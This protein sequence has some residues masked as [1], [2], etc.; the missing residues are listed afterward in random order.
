MAVSEQTRSSRD[1]S[2]N[3]TFNCKRK[4]ECVSLSVTPFIRLCTRYWNAVNTFRGARYQLSSTNPRGRRSSTVLSASDSLLTVH[5]ISFIRRLTPFTCERRLRGSFRYF[6][7]RRSL[8]TMLPVSS[9]GRWR[10]DGNT[11][12]PMHEM[13]AKTTFPIN[14]IYF[15]CFVVAVVVVAIAWN[16]LTF[17]RTMRTTIKWKILSLK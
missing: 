6:L 16:A 3:K 1:Q 2:E 5:S 17:N 4:R 7:L 12:S 11:C 9:V 13:H 10:Y 14:V 8:S 15:R